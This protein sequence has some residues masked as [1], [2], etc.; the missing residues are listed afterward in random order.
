MKLRFNI[1]SGWSPLRVA[2]LVI[3]VVD[4]GC[5]YAYYLTRNPLF[6]VLAAALAIVVTLLELNGHKKEEK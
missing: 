4:L 5:L 3:S 1:L 2:L 6:V